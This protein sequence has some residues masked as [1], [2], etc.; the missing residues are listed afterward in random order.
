[1]SPFVFS[2]LLLIFLSFFCL[3]FS[4][5][6]VFRLASFFELAQEDMVEGVWRWVGEDNWW[7]GGEKKME[8][9]VV[10]VGWWCSSSAHSKEGI[11]KCHPFPCARV[12]RVPNS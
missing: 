4:F 10:G 9:S 6:L 3:L 7:E 12:C 1:M 2:V 11:R 8:R 5:G